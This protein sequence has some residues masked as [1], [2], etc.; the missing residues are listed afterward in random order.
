MRVDDAYEAWKQA[1]P[2]Q[3]EEKLRDLH[4]AIKK[5]SDWLL[6]K[7]KG[8]NVP[9]LADNVAGDVLT[10]LDDFRGESKFSTWVGRVLTNKWADALGE[11]VLTRERFVEYTETEYRED[12][13]SL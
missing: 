4:A 8:Q 1:P 13:D 3:K 7:L 5:Y 6:W 2:A 12:P 11:R 9:G 10:H